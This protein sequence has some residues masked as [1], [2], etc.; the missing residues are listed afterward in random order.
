[1]R[2]KII[3]HFHTWPKAYHSFKASIRLASTFIKPS[4][5]F[6]LMIPSRGQSGKKLHYKCQ[7]QG[8]QPSELFYT[9][10]Q[11]GRLIAV[12]F[13]SSFRC[14]FKNPRELIQSIRTN[15]SF[16]KYFSWHSIDRQVCAGVYMAGDGTRGGLSC[17]VLLILSMQQLQPWP[18]T[19]GDMTFTFA[20]LKVDHPEF[21]CCS[22]YGFDSPWDSWCCHSS[23]VPVACHPVK[24]LQ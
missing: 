8:T 1:M 24:Q 4:L 19:S 23:S 3:Q 9:G 10:F 12:H 18:V 17:S 13:I 2:L 6:Q 16:Q 7:F 5:S 20:P 15:N 22:C 21:E 14:V 11:T